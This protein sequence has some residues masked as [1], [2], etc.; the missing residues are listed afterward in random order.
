MAATR[1]KLY[2]AFQFWIG[3]S[4]ARRPWA[5]ILHNKLKELGDCAEKE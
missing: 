4:V 1:L 3:A 5:R 2:D